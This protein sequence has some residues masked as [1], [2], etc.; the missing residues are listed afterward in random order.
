MDTFLHAKNSNRVP[1]MFQAGD[2]RSL[3]S[4]GLQ[5]SQGDRPQPNNHTNK[6]KIAI[7]ITSAAKKRKEEQTGVSGGNKRLA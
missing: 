1:A 3:P 6:Y 4:G 7:V 5:Y 2:D